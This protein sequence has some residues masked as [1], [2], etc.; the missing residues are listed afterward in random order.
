MGQEHTDRMALRLAL[1]RHV[2]RTVELFLETPQQQISGKLTSINGNE[3]SLSLPS[4]EKLSVRLSAICG[5]CVVK[6][7]QGANP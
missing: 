4:G 5:V 1:R 3:A 2:G 7:E 6:D